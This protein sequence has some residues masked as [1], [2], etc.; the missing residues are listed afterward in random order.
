[1]LT[2]IFAYALVSASVGEHQLGPLGQPMYLIIMIQNSEV[3]WHLKND[4]WCKDNMGDCVCCSWSSYR[5]LV[6]S[7]SFVCLSFCSQNSQE[8]QA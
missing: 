4:L 2:K 1:M 3:I 5:E 8:A 6:L 7:I